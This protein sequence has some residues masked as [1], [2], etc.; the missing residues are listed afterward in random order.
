VRL[1]SLDYADINVFNPAAAAVC[2]TL[3][4]TTAPSQGFESQLVPLSQRILLRFNVTAIRSNNTNPISAFESAH[5]LSP[6]PVVLQEV[7]NLARGRRIRLADPKTN[8][9]EDLPVEFLIGGDSYCKVI[10]ELPQ[11][12]SRNR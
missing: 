11:S 1:L 12:A 3:V 8:I 5:R 6:Q 2:G 4:G 7:G 9:Q 10:K